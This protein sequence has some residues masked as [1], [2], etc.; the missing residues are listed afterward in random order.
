MLLCTYCAHLKVL[1]PDWSPIPQPHSGN[2]HSISGL[3]P[4]C[5]DRILLHSFWQCPVDI[6]E[7]LMKDHPDGRPP[8]WETTL[9]GDHPDGRPPWWETT[10]LLGPLLM[11]IFSQHTLE[12]HHSHATGVITSELLRPTTILCTHQRQCLSDS[13]SMMQMT[14]D[15]QLHT[16]HSFFSDTAPVICLTFS[17]ST[18][19]QDSSAPPLTRELYAFH[20]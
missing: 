7:T 18:L 12:W 6:V 19:L 11:D 4:R 9:M 3:V 2:P 15:P 8:W 1:G 17:V 5:A 10:P 20:T 14:L 16:Y 13:R